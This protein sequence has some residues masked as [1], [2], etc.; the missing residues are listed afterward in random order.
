MSDNGDHIV[1]LP[2]LAHGHQIPFL[3]LAKQIQQRTPFTITIATTSLNVQYL[4]STLT[5][6]SSIRFA[7]LP[8]SSSDHN[9]PPNIEST[10]NLP[11]TKLGDFFLASRSLE[12]PCR[13]FIQ[14]L[15][16]EEGRP[17]ICIISD[18]F[19]GWAVDV[20]KSF[21]T[22]NL[23]FSTGG[24]YGTA[25]YMSLWQN[26]PHRSTDADEFPVPGF[27]EHC[28]FHRSQ[29]HLFLR[30][31][32]GTDAWSTFFQ[33]QISLSLKSFGCLCNT[34]EE[35]EPFGL[36]I[37]R[38]Y[39]KMPVW[40]IGPLLPQETLKDSSSSATSSISKQRVGK[41]VGISAEK[42]IEWMNEQDQDSVL[43]ISFG[44]QNTISAS[45][46]MELAIGLEKSGKSFIWVVRPPL[47][48][49]LKGEFRAEWLP[50]GF[51]E[52]MKEKNRGLVVRNWAPQLDILSHKSTGVFLSHC[53][54]NSV[55][56]SLSQGVPIIGWPL[57]GEQAY[58][59]KMMTED[60]GVSVEL[61]RGVQSVVVGEEVEKVINLAMDRNGKGREMKKRAEEVK[62]QIRAAI[63]EEGQQKG[64][65]LKAMDDFVASIL[66][67]REEQS[68][69]TTSKLE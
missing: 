26:L 68:K 57:A 41:E 18:V 60:M 16:E 33:G 29:L 32:D 9:L 36:E 37:L 14:N 38:N 50:E 64:S 15:V 42:C 40:C 23:T 8:F 25:G 45:Q 13:R 12:A 11:P 24:A 20:A 2:F 22:V 35:I 49:N 43:Y 58:N 65:S 21:G 67:N 51:E 4:R 6:D 55:M 66:A 17:P 69:P 54:W 31:A 3:A 61:N 10:E 5:S 62:M 47:G 52:R 44:S 53:G 63:R 48:F 1:M 7:D 28:R 39:M 46:M 56:E 19:L 27:P 34:V 59:S 30:S